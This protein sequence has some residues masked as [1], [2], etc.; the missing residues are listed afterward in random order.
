VMPM[1]VAGGLYFLWRKL[2]TSRVFGQRVPD[3]V[4]AEAVPSDRKPH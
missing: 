2:R 3:R 4:A 1:G